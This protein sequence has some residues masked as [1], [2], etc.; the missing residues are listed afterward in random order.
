MTVFG[1]TALVTD[2]NSIDSVISQGSCC[3]YF[4]ST[5]CIAERT[6]LRWL[7][8]SEGIVLVVIF[9]CHLLRLWFPGWSII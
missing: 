5:F 3:R 1:A 9:F 7:N 2:W 6:P 4:N 8:V